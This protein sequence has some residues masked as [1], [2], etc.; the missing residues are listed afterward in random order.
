MLHNIV[1]FF[2]CILEVLVFFLL[3]SAVFPHIALAGVVPDL[4]MI[5]VITIAYTRGRVRGLFVGL[6]AGLLVDFTY[7]DFV[8]LFALFY[9]VIGYLVGYSSKIYDSEDYTIPLLLCGVSEFV[10]NL[11]Y[12]VFF[13]L[14]Q[15]KLNMGYYIYRFAVPR[16]IYTVLIS[17][18]VFKLLNM[19]HLALN[20]LRRDEVV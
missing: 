16:I 18:L 7:G 12:Y 9:M 6:L 13:F 17:I 1:R 3:Q 4:L 15:G 5:L 10:Y 20:K 8:G 19:I 11:L 14:L 2:V